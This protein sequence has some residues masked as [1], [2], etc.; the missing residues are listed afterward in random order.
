MITR[1][2]GKNIMKG[3]EWHENKQ[4]VITDDMLEKDC[5]VGKPFLEP[6][7]TIINYEEI[8]VFEGQPFYNTNIESSHF[9]YGGFNRIN[10]SEDEE[11]KVEEQ[12][13]RADLNELHLRTDKVSSIEVLNEEEAN[14]W[15]QGKVKEFNQAMINSNQKLK[16]YCS[17]H[18]L[19]PEDT[20]CYELFTIVYPDDKP[21]IVNGKFRA[22]DKNNVAYW[23]DATVATDCSGAPLFSFKL[24]N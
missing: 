3:F 17:V 23:G 11:V 7:E 21:E 4:T 13:F 1:V 8:C 12:I 18:K 20:D 15:L 5:F 16:E 10:I 22:K 2:F 19:S 14:E 9:Y 24:N 6:V